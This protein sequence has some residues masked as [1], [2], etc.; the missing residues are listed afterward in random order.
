MVEA[1]GRYGN[2]LSEVG[3]WDEGQ[4][5]LGDAVKLAIEVKNDTV[6]A[7]VLDQLGDSYFYRGDYRIARQQYEKNVAGCDQVEKPRTVGQLT[8]QPGEARCR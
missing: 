1:T 6:L 8:L 4:T 2:A 7:Q 5:S 3:R